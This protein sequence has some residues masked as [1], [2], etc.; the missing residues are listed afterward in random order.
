MS[1]HGT[2][3]IFDGIACEEMGLAL[4]DF[5]TVK[6]ETTKF[7]SNLAVQEDRIGGRYRSLFYGGTVNEPL[8]FTMVLCVREDKAMRNE[9][10]D[11]W[12]LQKVAS[13]LT[14]HTSYKWLQ[15]VQND[16]KDVRYRCICSDLTVVEVAGSAWGFSCKVTCDSPYAYLTPMTYS[17]TATASQPA[18]GIIVSESTHN[19]FYY[20][21]LTITPKTNGGNLAVTISNNT[22]TETFTMLG[23]PTKFG[24]ISIDCE[25]EVVTTESGDNPYGYI[26]FRN[27]FHFPRFARGENTVTLTG[28]G[29]YQFVCE[30][31][32]NV[33]G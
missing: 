1:F 19:G 4:Y 24:T 27:G 13:W 8:I 7:T 25:N 30:W 31:P 15:I 11:R 26:D 33:G 3:M 32:V 5:D 18:S 10:L 28:A 20:P 9:P 14:G 17:F 29:T 16:M 6:Q 22:E 21:K 12:D 2:S 23:V